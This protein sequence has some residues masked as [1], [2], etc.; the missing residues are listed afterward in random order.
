MDLDLDMMTHD[1]FNFFVEKSMDSMDSMD[2]H[3]KSVSTMDL[4]LDIMTHD[5]WPFRKLEN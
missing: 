2:L 1:I 5:I 3:K 4:D